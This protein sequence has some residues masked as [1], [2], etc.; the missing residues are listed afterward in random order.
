MKY[1]NIII[2]PIFLLLL[3]GCNDK[4]KQLD[5]FQ[6]RKHMIE[7]QLKARD[8]TDEDVLHAMMKVER[9]KFVPL[10]FRDL[11]YSDQPLPIGEGQTISQPYIVALMTQLADLE[12]DDRVLEIGTGSGYQVA[13]LAQICKEVY[14]IEILKPLA[15]QSRKKLKQLGYDNIEVKCGDGYKGWEEFAPFDAVIVT[16]APP[17][18]PQPLIQQLKEG[19]R[20]VIPVGERWQ[21]LKVIKKV[22]GEIESKIIIPVKFVPMTGEGVKEDYDE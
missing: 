5:Y 10:V 3:S 18:V 6:A 15:D 8:I 17:K 12:Q 2:F 22:N 20:L 7:A 14:T 9:H 16:C 21:N 19:G 4:S 11:A 13:V 1:N